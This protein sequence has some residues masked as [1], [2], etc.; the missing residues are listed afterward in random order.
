MSVVSRSKTQHASVLRM[1]E[2]HQQFQKRLAEHTG[3]NETDATLFG[4]LMRAGAPL[5]A[6]R[7]AQIASLTTGATTTAIDRLETLGLVQRQRSDE[8]RRTVLVALRQPNAR[9]VMKQMEP[10]A[11]LWEQLWEQFSEREC[12]AIER[13]VREYTATME[14][15]LTDK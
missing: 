11:D 12:E 2:V 13:F 7:L 9:K 4:A 3:L 15:A 5:S 6:G 14:V 10:L 8:D 1:F